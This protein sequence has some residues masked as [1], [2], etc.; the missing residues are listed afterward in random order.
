MYWFNVVVYSGFLFLLS[1]L[2]RLC[3]KSK[4]KKKQST[5]IIH[6]I[7]ALKIK[8]MQTNVYC[9]SAS[10]K[11]NL[12]QQLSHER[13]KFTFGNNRKSSL[14]RKRKYQTEKQRAH[15]Q[16]VVKSEEKFFFLPNKQNTVNSLVFLSFNQ[17]HRI[18]FHLFAR[19]LAR[20][21]SLCVFFFL[22]LSSID[23]KHLYK[24]QELKMLMHKLNS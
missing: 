7:C 3:E 15:F 5:H 12:H 13:Y 10:T 1:F 23:V 18:F 20:L 16:L 24:H 21:L 17:L 4:E 11:V 14:K 8:E 22:Y 6:I 2:L 19:L 9:I